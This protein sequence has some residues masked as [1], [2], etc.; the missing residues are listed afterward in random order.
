MI[1]TA[2]INVRLP[3]EVIRILDSLIEKELFSTRSEAIREFLREHL[4]ESNESAS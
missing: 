1:E 4:E 2:V 3:E